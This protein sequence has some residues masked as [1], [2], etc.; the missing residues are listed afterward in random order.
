MLGSDLQVPIASKPV[1]LRKGINGLA[2]MVST[3]LGA[4]PYAIG[5]NLSAA[6]NEVTKGSYLIA[7]A[8]FASQSLS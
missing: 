5:K 3:T 7:R 6:N 2:A 4:N 8:F 1:D